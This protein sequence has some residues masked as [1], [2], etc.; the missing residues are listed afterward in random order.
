MSMLMLASNG[1]FPLSVALSGL[2]VRDFGPQPFFPASGIVLAAAAVAA[3]S[4]RE[5]RRLGVS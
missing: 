1:A 4:R 2:L 3:M 5:I